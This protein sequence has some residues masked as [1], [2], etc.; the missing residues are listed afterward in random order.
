MPHDHDDS[1]HP[2]DHVLNHNKQLIELCEKLQN[3]VDELK[4]QQHNW[5][6]SSVCRELQHKLDEMTEYADKLAAGFPE[7]M[8]PKDVEVLREANFGLAQEV[9]KVKDQRDKLINIIEKIV[10]LS[11]HEPGLVLDYLLSVPSPVRKIHSE[12]KAWKHENG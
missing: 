9:H 11:V 8:L 12:M 2:Y 5:R 1:G 3:E 10:E 6:M 4:N 7:G